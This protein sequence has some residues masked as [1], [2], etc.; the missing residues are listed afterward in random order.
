[1]NR[2]TN[3]ISNKGQYV[4][5]GVERSTGHA[6]PLWIS[7]SFYENDLHCSIP[8]YIIYAPPTNPRYTKDTKLDI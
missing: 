3:D 5:G 2:Y 8:S 7:F 6:V 4:L 1:M